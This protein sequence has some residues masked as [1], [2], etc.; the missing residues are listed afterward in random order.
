MRILLLLAVVVGTLTAA[1]KPN[2]IIIMTD[3]M[4]YTDLGCFGSEIETPNL[5]ALAT[6]GLRFTQFYNTGRCCPTRA[7][8][9]TGLYSHQAGVGG[10][11]KDEGPKRPGYRGRLTE[12]CVTIAE[13]LGPAGYHTIQA[14]KWHVGGAK[15]EWWPNNRGF[16]RSFG[17]PLGGGFYF[18]PS[19]FKGYREVVRNFDVL[20]TPKIDPPEGWYTTDAYTEEGLGFVREA[21]EAEKP[22]FWYL[23]YNAPHWPLRAKAEDIAKYRGR[24]RVGWDEIRRQRHERLV[25]SGI[26]DA[27]H[28]LT[29]RPKGI[30][31]WDSLTGEQKDE[32]DLRMATYA[33]MVDCVDQ[34]VG[35]LV[36]ELKRLSQYENT[37]IMFLCDN[38]GSPEGGP[39]GVNKGKGVCGTP[40][41]YA[42]YGECW[43][44]VSSS[45][46]RRY[47]KFIHEGG[48][49][50]PFV[51]H[52]PKGIKT[53]LH[54]SLV[55]E[56]TH[57][58]DLMATCVD[59]A[60]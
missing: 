26:L 2:V 25:K 23:A 11:T 12:R 49:A 3:D 47:K 52:W 5:D 4:G 9:L 36:E 58:I 42:Y 56:P 55:G 10:M 48:I 38:G 15:K 24:Y 40:E 33:A 50:T 41:S 44:N 6:K 32:Q 37:L 35:K 19:A 54:G 17:S 39:L 46:F 29:P 57:V 18:R 13:V 31:A 30:P 45:P 21:V 20:Y 8:L 27:K 22:F 34:N 28:A 7:S 51:A 43:A 53:E 16:N 1:E 60:G 14:G 59:L